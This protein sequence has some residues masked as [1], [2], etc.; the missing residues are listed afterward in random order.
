MFLLSKRLYLSI[1]FKYNEFPKS[2][3][4]SSGFINSIMLSIHSSIL[5]AGRLSM[6]ILGLCVLFI[7]CFKDLTKNKFVILSC[8]IFSIISKFFS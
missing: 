8:S 2:A 3:I 6:I 7:S 4:V 5:S 1:D